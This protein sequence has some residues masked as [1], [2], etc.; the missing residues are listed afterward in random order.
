MLR[1]CD[2][3]GTI[4]A[5]AVHRRVTSGAQVT[6]KWPNDV[7]IDGEKVSGVLIEIED[8][9]LFVGIG[10]NVVSAPLVSALGPN[11]AR[12]ATCLAAHNEAI[13]AYIEQENSTP[14]FNQVVDVAGGPQPSTDIG[15]G[16]SPLRE[17]DFH[18]ELA[19]EI[20]AAVHN[21]VQAQSDSSA[22]VLTDFE[23]NLDRSPQ[24][25][26]DG[27]NNAVAGGEEV[28]PISVN[29]DGTLRVKSTVSGV[30]RTLVAD[31]LW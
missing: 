13:A 30:E 22:L 1:R 9:V 29:S 24:K 11:G 12:P 15:P 18:K 5:S 27:N 23:R 7:L 6:L 17:G 26:R 20:C 2:R 21:W 3:I 31:Y 8:G 19:I 28:L 14:S 25:L 4:V 16:G 10:C